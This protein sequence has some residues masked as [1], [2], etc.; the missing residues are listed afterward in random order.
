VVVGT[1]GV[2]QVGGQGGGLV[3]GADR[4]GHGLEGRRR[5]AEDRSDRH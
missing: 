3:D 5:E 1:H 4:L 2:D